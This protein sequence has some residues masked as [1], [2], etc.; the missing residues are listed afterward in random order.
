MVGWLELDEIAPF[1]QS[2]DMLIH[3]SFFDPFPNVV[4]EAM[5]V[6]LPVMGSNLAG[7]VVDRVV[8]AKNGY[9]CAAG[10]PIDWANKIEL[11]LKAP[12]IL[13]ELGQAARRTAEAH[14]VDENIKT[15]QRCLVVSKAKSVG[16]G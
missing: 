16:L 3:S 4:L 7:S 14:P 6:G 13:S 8:P 15:L 9:I 2:G 1:Y 11:V 10:D 5:A 12:E